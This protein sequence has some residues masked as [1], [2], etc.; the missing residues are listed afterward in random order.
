MEKGNILVIGNSGVGK[1]TLINAVLGTD[2]AETG[3]GT[4]GTTKELK[5]YENDELPFRLI[6][7]IGFEPSFFK[8]RSAVNAVKKWSRESAKAGKT[9]TQ[10]N[11]IWFCV[12]GTSGKLFPKAIQ[13]LC[14][15][16]SHWPSVPVIV[17]ITKS[18]SVPDREQNIQLVYNAFAR[19][20]KFAKNLK[21]VIPVVAQTFVLNDSAYAPPE[22]IG[23]LIE[24]SNVLLPEGIQ[25]AQKDV[26]AYILNTKRALAQGLIVAATS[27]A[28]VV[29]AV[30]IP[31]PD[32]FFLCAIETAEVNGLSKVYGIPKN[33]DSKRF[34]NTIVEIGTVSLVA[35]A[36]LNAVKAIP[37]LNLA[38]AAVNAIVAG[39][40][41]AAL[42]EG[43]VYAFEQ[44]Y[45]GKKSLEDIDWI[46]QVMESRLTVEFVEKLT[47]ILGKMQDN[48]SAKNM[49]EAILEMFFR[50]K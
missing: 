40:I 1:S 4:G 11:L 38:A 15:A 3:G 17:V 46:K 26:A 23:E 6:D 34:F 21:N 36:A 14:N 27:A 22:G 42:G 33:E 8:E 32:A 25:A 35:K 20:K 19:Q 39:C 16:T 29:G 24:A 10:I 5:V 31:Y 2:A 13:T 44:I 18:Y 12:E 49:V 30:P 41:V 28:V 47:K 7:T 45:L 37:G 43:S 48:P 50:K 9:D